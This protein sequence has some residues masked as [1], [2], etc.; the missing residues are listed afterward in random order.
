M[1][2][3][4]VLSLLV[5][6]IMA[7]FSATGLS[8]QDSISAPVSKS[9][10]YCIVSFDG[11]KVEKE[12]QIGSLT[13]KYTERLYHMSVDCRQYDEDVTNIFGVINDEDGKPR[14]FSSHMAGI[15]WLGLM[16]WELVPYPITY[17]PEYI[18]E[19]DYWLR[20][21]VTGLSHD[22]INRKLSVFRAKK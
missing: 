3:I 1:K 20:M 9:Y 13:Q 11:L 15:N 2:N 6:I 19:I 14:E 7:G 21:D 18:V 10:V 22:E 12:K 8:A 4:K 17:K 16:G 5:A